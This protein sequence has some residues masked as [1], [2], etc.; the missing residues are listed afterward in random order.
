MTTKCRDILVQLSVCQKDSAIYLS[1]QESM[2]PD[3]ASDQD[4]SVCGTFCN[5]PHGLSWSEL[6]N[7]DKEYKMICREKWTEILQHVSPNLLVILSL[8]LFTKSE[9]TKYHVLFILQHGHT[10]SEMDSSLSFLF[11][12]PNKSIRSMK[13]QIQTER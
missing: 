3:V 5:Y 9:S 7:R 10:S 2:S 1:L 13:K 11:Q 4:R 6:K 12:H 8:R